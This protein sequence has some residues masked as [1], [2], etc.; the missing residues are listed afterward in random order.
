[1][2]QKRHHRTDY[3]FTERP[4]AVNLW[5]QP[6]GFATAV[7]AAGRLRPRTQ[8]WRRK[9]AKKASAGT[10]AVA[11]A[12]LGLLDAMSMPGWAAFFARLQHLSS[13]R[14]DFPTTSANFSSPAVSSLGFGAGLLSASAWSSFVFFSAGGRYLR[15]SSLCRCCSFSSCCSPYP[16]RCPFRCEHSSCQ[17]CC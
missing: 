10:D 17:S 13:T 5:H 9:W 1:M 8:G 3:G 16:S 14:R 7:H 6:F 15:V 11:T 4:R 2:S 12:N